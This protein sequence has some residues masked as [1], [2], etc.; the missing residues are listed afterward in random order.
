MVF[1]KPIYLSIID[2]LD[3]VHFFPS[4]LSGDSNVQRFVPGAETYHEDETGFRSTGFRMPLKAGDTLLLQCQSFPHKKLTRW[5][6]K[7]K[8]SYK[9]TFYQQS[10]ATPTPRPR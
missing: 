3:T 1:G 6:Y 4:V 7:V 8:V 5:G 10:F 9:Y 2:E